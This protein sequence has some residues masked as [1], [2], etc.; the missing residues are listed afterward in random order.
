MIRHGNFP[1]INL[2]ILTETGSTAVII[3]NTAS[4]SESLVQGGIN[5]FPSIETLESASQLD[6]SYNTA[7][8]EFYRLTDRNGG[9]T[10][11]STVLNKPAT[12]NVS[13]LYATSS[14]TNP[15]IGI[16]TNDPK[17]IFDFKDIKDDNRGGEILI[18]SSRSTKGAEVGDEAGRINFTIDSSSFNDIETSGSV[19]QILA[20]VSDVSSD[21]VFGGLS[22]QVAASSKQPSVERIFISPSETHITGSVA[23]SSYIRTTAQNNALG[24]LRVGSYGSS[25]DSGDLSVQSEIEVFGNTENALRLVNGGIT[26]ASTTGKGNITASGDIS[27]SGNLITTDIT[28]SGDLSILGGTIDLKNE[29]SA[30]KILFYCESNNAHAQTVQAAPHSDVASNTLVLPSTGTKFATQDGTETFTNKTLTSPDINTPDI[31]GGTIDNTVIGNSTA[32]AGTFTSLTATSITSSGNISASGKLITSELSAPG[33]LTID[34]DGADIL[35]KDGGTEFGRF[36]RDTS[37]FVIKSAENNKDIVF[38]G[39]DSGATITALTLD[40][41]EAGSATFN[42][43]ITASGNISASGDI[44]SNTLSTSGDITSNT[45]ETISTTLASDSVT[46]VDTFNSS[47]YN[48][49]IYD[50]ILKDT[51]VGARAGQFMIAHDGGSVTFTDTST[52]HLTDSTIPEITADINGADVR[53]RVTNG[54]GYTFKSFVKKL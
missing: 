50:Y 17:R 49:A 7:P 6:F 42:N 25:I 16:G 37:D 19:A 54:N 9:V 35:L 39:Q 47:S 51:G 33:D 40:M 34:A 52:K 5:F 11:E 30:S 31:D 36:K 14:G 41:S 3:N 26:L 2:N 4:V 38:R 44:T 18:R 46:N 28:A 20:K 32:N 29:G 53:V 43:H 22:L 10:I 13:I 21:G 12:S 8:F 23:L 27:A 48:G 15:R 1:P 24:S 45:F